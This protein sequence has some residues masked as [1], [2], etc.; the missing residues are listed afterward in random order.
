M[1]ADI[2]DYLA[3]LSR[4]RFYGSVELWFQDGRLVQVQQHQ[5]YKPEDGEIRLTLV[6]GKPRDTGGAK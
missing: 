1:L 4:S 6:R 3:N 2:F 5:S